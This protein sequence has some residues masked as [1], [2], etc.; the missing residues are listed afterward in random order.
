MCL[1]ILDAY[2]KVSKFSF[3]VRWTLSLITKVV[4][5]AIW[6]RGK[7]FTRQLRMYAI[8]ENGLSQ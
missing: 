5:N 6:R 7:H 2:D 4:L 1:D 3:L 8:Y